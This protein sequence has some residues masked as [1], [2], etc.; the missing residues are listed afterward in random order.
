M[1][2]VGTSTI[3]K[4][5]PG[6][7]TRRPNARLARFIET[8]SL[9]TAR[10]AEMNALDEGLPVPPA[11][12]I[13]ARLLVAA[14]RD[15]DVFRGMLEIAMCVALPQEVIARR[16]V[17]ARLAGW[18]AN[19]ANPRHHRSTSDGGATGWLTFRSPRR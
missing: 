8:K 2:L 9:R 10:I 15:A 6:T 3:P 19:A 12:P 1:L 17:A 11:N 16:H 5:S 13:M 18:P 14:S 7:T 4:P